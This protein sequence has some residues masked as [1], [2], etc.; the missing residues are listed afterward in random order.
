MLKNKWN[1]F[2][3]RSYDSSE[4]VNYKFENFNSIA[5]V[6]YPTVFIILISFKKSMMGFFATTMEWEYVVVNEYTCAVFADVFF[7]D[8]QVFPSSCSS[9]IEIAQLKCTL[10]NNVSYS[11]YVH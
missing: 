10:S 8:I 4:Y 7:C 1:V 11:I 2:I 9:A 3:F 6:K 5:H